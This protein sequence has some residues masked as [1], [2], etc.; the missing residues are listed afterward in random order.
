[1]KSVFFYCSVVITSL[2]LLSSCGK[3]TV[4][5][6]PVKPDTTVTPPSESRYLTQAIETNAFIKGNLLTPYGNYRINTTTT[7]NTAYE[8]YNV[9][10]I[11]ADAAMVAAGDKNYLASMHKTFDWMKNMWD[12]NDPNGGYFAA[13]NLDGANAG[14]DKYVDDNGL[15]GMVY[16]DCY[17]LADNDRK[18]D[19]LEAA[20]KAANWMMHS[21]LWDDTHGGGFWWSTAKQNKPTQTNGLA[22]QL[23]LRLY[24]ITGETYYRD[25]AVS[26]HNWLNSKMYDS[27]TGLYIWM[28]DS[29]G[30]HTEIFAY[31]NAI[32]LEAFL[33]WKDVMNDNAYLGK[34]QAIGNAMNK[35][36]W[37]KGYNV[38]IFNTKDIRV[39]PA[40]CGWA[41]QA[42]IKL[43]EA[44]KNTAWLS[45]AKGN[46]DAINNVLRSTANKG[47]YQFAGLNGAGRY[48]N[49]EG[50]D[51]AWMQRIQAMLSKY[52]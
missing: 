37:D 49:M 8:W 13:A 25:W 27:N 51:Q 47:Y 41:S 17:D 5:P 43:Y 3:E 35:T 21:G 45:Y 33:I 2:V 15:T 38:Y 19:Y 29:A 32:M 23:F 24:K 12:K 22:M 46:I 34:A 18:A 36:L 26:I 7:E 52:K 30:K 31:D 28:Y 39:T 1:M 50:V 6:A 44:D 20:K 10:Q 9:S 16:L 14:G 48:T 4:K 40:W 11:Y 42:M